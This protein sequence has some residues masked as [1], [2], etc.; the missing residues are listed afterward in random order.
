LPDDDAPPVRGIGL[1]LSG[2]GYRA[3]LFDAGARR[4]Q[5]AVAVACSSAAICDAAPRRHLDPDAARPLGFPYPE[6]AV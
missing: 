2:G 6:A 3:M 1:C 4:S 5:L